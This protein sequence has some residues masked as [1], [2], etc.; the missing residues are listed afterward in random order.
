MSQEKKHSKVTS[1]WTDKFALNFLAKGHT[2]VPWDNTNW[3]EQQHSV[4]WSIMNRTVIFL[5]LAQLLNSVYSEDLGC[6]TPDVTCINSLIFD[7]IK[8]SDASACAQQC[9][10]RNCLWFKPSIYTIENMRYER[11]IICAGLKRVKHIY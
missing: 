2:I 10:V 1:K 7:S 4:D 8:A 11:L 6:F 3:N 5:V 9:T